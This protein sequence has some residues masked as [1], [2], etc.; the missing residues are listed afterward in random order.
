MGEEERRGEGEEEWMGG[1]GRDK[2][3]RKMRG[4]GEI[5]LDGAVV[6]VYVRPAVCKSL[7]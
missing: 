3:E 1:V 4:W 6:S 7:R 5:R 2:I